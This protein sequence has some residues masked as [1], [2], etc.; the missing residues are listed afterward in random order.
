MTLWLTDDEV[1]SFTGYKRAGDQVRWLTRN[2]FLER[3]D[4]FLTAAGRPRLLRA[5]LDR[6]QLVSLPPVRATEPDFSTVR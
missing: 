1:A 3:A 4:Y 5:A 2:G 6:K